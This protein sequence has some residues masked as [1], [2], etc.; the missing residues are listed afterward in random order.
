MNEVDLTSLK[1]GLGES[2]NLSCQIIYKRQM[3][4]RLGT[5]QGSE[6]NR[7]G[8]I[9]GIQPLEDPASLKRPSRLSLR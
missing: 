8:R 7:V 2:C 3:A 1:L 4:V 6:N 5:S 9:V